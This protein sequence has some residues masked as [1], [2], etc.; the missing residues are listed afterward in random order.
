MLLKN[1]H[2]LPQG[3]TGSKGEDSTNEEEGVDNVNTIDEESSISSLPATD[4]RS[5]YYNLVSW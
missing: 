5:Y 1:S 3:L 4:G 2:P